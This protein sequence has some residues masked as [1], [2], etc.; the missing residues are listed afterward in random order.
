MNIIVVGCERLGS[1][2][3]DSL[4]HQGHTV[5]I[6]DT[7]ADAFNLL[8][9]DFDGLTVLGVPMDMNVL[10]NAGIES[11]DAVAVV[12]SDDNLNITIAQIVKEFFYIENVVTRIND[13]AREQVFYSL[14]LNTFCPT[15]LACSVLETAITQESRE[16]QVNLG[17]HTLGINLRPLNSRFFGRSIS[18]VPVKP[19]EI[20]IGVKR[21]D[22]DVILY[23]GKKEIILNPQDKII[24]ARIAD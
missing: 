2:L 9:D 24:Y 14:G 17:V 4:S 19:G 6:I 5:C 20:I 11:C 12:T 7:N 16:K 18:N 23:D 1:R 22:N 10:R 8:S 3:A 21:N 15:K 13:P